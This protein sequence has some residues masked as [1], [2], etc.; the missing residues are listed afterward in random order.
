MNKIFW[1]GDSTVQTNDYS[2]F[3]QTGIGQVFSLFLR[4]G[5]QVVNHAKNGRSTKSFLDEGRFEAIA[6]QI[7]EGDFLFIQFGHNDEKK[8][9]PTR[10]TDPDSSFRENLRLFVETARGRKAYPVLITP[11]ERRCFEDEGHLG[12]GAHGE[13]VRAMRQAAGDFNVPLVDLY[14]MSRAAL[15]EAGEVKS[16]GWY[17]YFDRG[18][19]EQHPEESRDNTHLR[20]AGAVKFA[21]LIAAGLQELGGVYGELVIDVKIQSH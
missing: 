12:Q 10:Y 15:E 17:M 19:Y 5:C 4:E 14:D 18:E 2:T 9:D 16:R 6:R 3:P 21:G 20:Y 13:Y 11:L 1:A 8:E 7:G